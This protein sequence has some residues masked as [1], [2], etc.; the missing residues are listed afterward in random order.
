[1]VRYAQTQER[2]VLVPATPE[3]MAHRYHA[4]VYGTRF[5][6]PTVQS[7]FDL[8]DDFE[9]ANP[10][11]RVMSY[12]ILDMFEEAHPKEEKGE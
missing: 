10:G 7:V 5:S 1:M 6:G 2:P 3:Q 12:I 9:E 8:I 11:R 4:T